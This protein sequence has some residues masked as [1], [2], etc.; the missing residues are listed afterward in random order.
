[1]LG[2]TLSLALQ[3]QRLLLIRAEI[4]AAQVRERERAIET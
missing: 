3:L 4:I 1:M 2:L